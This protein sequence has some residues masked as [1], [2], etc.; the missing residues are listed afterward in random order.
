MLLQGLRGSHVKLIALSAARNSVRHG[1]GLGFLFLALFA[2]LIVANAFIS[3]VEDF[4]KVSPATGGGD[5]V[6]D[7]VDQVVEEV[8]KPAIR[9]ALGMD[10]EQ[11]EYMV[12]RRP[13]IVSAIL[14]VLLILL[15]FL[16]SFGAFNQ[17]TGDIRSRGLRYLLLRTERSNLFLGRFLGTYVFTVLVLFALVLVVLLY[18]VLKARF[19]PTGDVVAWMAI[20]FA[21]LAVFALPYVALCAWISAASDSPFVSLVISQL[22]IGFVP[23]IAYMAGKVEPK[24]AYLSYAMP[25]GFKFKLL[26]P[27]FVQFGGAA[28]AMLAFT[29]VFLWLGAWSFQRRDL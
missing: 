1:S 26:H 6:R 5:D 9:W 14:L 4:H 7:L 13:A 2:G 22:V 18:L 29:A 12:V 19:Y 17:L 8:G 11:V 10:E 23:L 25:W 24:L 21:A 28:L 20:G 27:A 16:V 3:P 15:P